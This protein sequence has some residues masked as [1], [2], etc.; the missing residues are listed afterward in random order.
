MVLCRLC[1]PLRGSHRNVTMDNFFTSVQALNKLR[2]E[3]QLTVIGTLRKNKPQ[4]PT[5]LC[6]RRPEKTST[7]NMHNGV[8][9]TKQIEM[10]FFYPQCIS[11]IT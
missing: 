9:H 2:N 11:T 8:I 3:Y 1:K 4:I 7:S 6:V 5:E 10:F